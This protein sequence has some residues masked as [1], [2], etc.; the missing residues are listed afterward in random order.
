MLRDSVQMRFKCANEIRHKL[1][2]YFKHVQLIS[3]DHYEIRGLGDQI[4]G[5]GLLKFLAP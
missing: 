5:G 1:F 3:V 4:M 2:S